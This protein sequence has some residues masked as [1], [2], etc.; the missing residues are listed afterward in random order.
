[1]IKGVKDVG[2]VAQAR[3]MLSACRH[4]AFEGPNERVKQTASSLAALITPRQHLLLQALMERRGPL[5]YRWWEA[6]SHSHASWVPCH[7]TLM[8]IHYTPADYRGD[9][10]SMLSP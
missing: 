2:L 4:L 10:I 7:R 5:K 9:A 1:M 3:S 8:M 6:G